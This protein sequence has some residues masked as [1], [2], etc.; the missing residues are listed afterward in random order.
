MVSKEVRWL[1]ALWFAGIDLHTMV[2]S[3]ST[4]TACPIPRAPWSNLVMVAT[5]M[6]Q[7]TWQI[8]SSFLGER[9]GS[10]KVTPCLKSVR[11]AMSIVSCACDRVL[12]RWPL[13]RPHY[14]LLIQ[15]TGL[16]CGLGHSSHGTIIHEVA[17]AAVSCQLWSELASHDGSRNCGP[18]L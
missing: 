13:H 18:V 15:I 9:F 16:A 3:G 5:L 6:W 17:I 2:A 7:R 12:H 4:W 8:M 1:Q 14:R 11:K 10:S